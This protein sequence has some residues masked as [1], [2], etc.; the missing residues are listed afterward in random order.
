MVNAIG[1]DVPETFFLVVF[2]FFSP[3][4]FGSPPSA[5]AA[6]GF[7]RFGLLVRSMLA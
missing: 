4:P 5:G 2:C 6:A 3:A 7:S 1:Y